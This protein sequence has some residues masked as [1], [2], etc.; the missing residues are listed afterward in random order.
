MQGIPLIEL[1]FGTVGS[2]IGL[3]WQ[4]ALFAVGG[5]FS[6]LDSTPL[7][8]QINKLISGATILASQIIGDL[9]V[10]ITVGGRELGALLSQIDSTGNYIGSLALSQI[11]GIAAEAESWLTSGVIPSVTT[12]VHT[13]VTDWDAATSAAISAASIALSQ[14]TGIAAA[15]ESWLTSGEIPSVTTIA[16]TAV[17]D[18]DA[19]TSAAISAASIALSQ[20]TGIVTEIES[21]LASGGAL[22]TGT[23]ISHTAIT[24][25]ST[26]LSAATFAAS[27]ISNVLGSANLGAD[28]Q[29]IV[30]NLANGLGQTG[31]G[32]T[33]A[34]LLSYIEAIPGGNIT[35]ALNTAATVAGVEIGSIQSDLASTISNLFGTTT[36]SVAPT[37]DATGAGAVGGLQTTTLSEP[38]TISGNAVLAYVVTWGAAELVAAATVGSAP[39]TLL[40]SV[41]YYD[42]SGIDGPNYATLFVFGLLNPPTGSQTIT[43]T[44]PNADQMSLD[45]VSYSGV[46]R[47]GSPVV[48]SALTGNPSLS[49]AAS[50]ADLVAQ[51]FA[52]ITQA[53]SSYNQT[54]RVNRPYSNSGTTYNM[55]SVAGDAPGASTVSFT[56]TGS[57]SV[58]WAGVAI[59]LVGSV[60]VGSELNNLLTIAGKE[61]G[62]VLT[63]LDDA[64]NYI[65]T[66]AHTA[67][68]DWDAATSTA[69]SAASIALSQIT[70]IAAEVESWLASGGALPTGTTVAHTA[71]TDWN[72]AT[73]TA[74][75]NAQIAG[76]QL[77]G[78]VSGGLISGPTTIEQGI[79]DGMGQALQGA[80][81]FVQQAVTDYNSAVATVQNWVSPITSALSVIPSV[82]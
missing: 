62:A 36:T 3:F 26:A 69:I 51:V 41:V 46:T 9:S 18:W 33:L 35:G 59:P 42:G 49:V 71:I 44:V 6:G 25:W 66:L 48:A 53:F 50:P 78:S 64:G 7:I 28:V 52:G 55:G 40:E 8:Q 27:Q 58:N 54:S 80:Q 74:I 61:L 19:A 45:S 30:D 24:D 11:T 23:T 21:W 67:I 76:T 65:G 20:I 16:H 5:F 47:F 82:W 1:I 29:A 38:H 77:V 63:Y 39:M 73:S 37:Y 2:E 31:T 14:I 68:T 72:T 32:H 4:S 12:I 70:G 75:S 81:S 34:N 13:A 10:L 56:A 15:A 17:T 57:N 43:A 60:T 79:V 22:P